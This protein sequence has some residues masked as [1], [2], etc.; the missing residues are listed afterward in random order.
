MLFGRCYKNLGY[1]RTGL[2]IRIKSQAGKKPE[3]WWPN[4]LGVPLPESF[5]LAFIN[6]HEDILGHKPYPARECPWTH[7]PHCKKNPL[8]L[9]T[10][11][12]LKASFYNA[13]IKS[14]L[15]FFF[16]LLSG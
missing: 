4:A 12:T 5:E 7:K 11:V 3:V 8:N 13:D 14:L 6:H 15:L 10:E 9:E 16:L 2:K 1:L